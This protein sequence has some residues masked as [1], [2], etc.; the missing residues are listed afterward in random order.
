MHKFNEFIIYEYCHECEKIRNEKLKVN[1]T[2]SAELIE[3][4]NLYKTFIATS[5]CTR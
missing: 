4:L 2:P 1:L 3:N 5:S